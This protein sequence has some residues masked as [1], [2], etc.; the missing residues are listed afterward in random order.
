MFASDLLARKG[1]IHS[2]KGNIRTPSFVPVVHPEPSKNLVTVADFQQEFNIDFIITSSY[3]LRKRFNKTI[4]DLHELTS[5][6]GPIMTDSGA[7]QSLLYGEIELLPEEVIKFQEEIGSDFAVPLDIPISLTDSFE[8]AHEKVKITI[9]RAKEA[10]EISSKASTCWVAPIQGGKF[11]SLVERSAKELT[12]I[13]FYSMFAIGSVVELMNNYRYDTLLQIILTAKKF[14]APE[15]PLHLFGAGHP[16]MFPFIVAAGIDTFDSAAY[17]LYAQDGRYLTNTQTFLLKD[18][19]EFPCNCPICSKTTPNELLNQPKLQQIQALAKHNLYICQAEIKTIREAISS[20]TLWNLL[21]SRSRAHPALRK[22]FDVLLK[23]SSI[24]LEN[25]PSTKKKGCFYV[26]ESDSQRPEVLLHQ[27]RLK[28]IDLT[29]RKKLIIFSLLA[30][31]DIN[32]LYSVFTRV[33]EF[34]KVN[35]SLIEEFD[36][37]IINDYYGIIPLEL[38]EVYPL[39]QSVFMEKITNI[40]RKFI[41]EDIFRRIKKWSYQE[42]ILAGN[43]NS[44]YDYFIEENYY[45]ESR[46]KIKS[47]NFIISNEHFQDL[48]FFL[49]SLIK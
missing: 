34:F 32:E 9:Q 14:L 6:A 18:L 49:N 47:Y 36:F 5:F 48:E 3:I 35:K 1:I 30:N 2:P 19:D 26:S 22:G 41:I 17:S 38:I 20:G 21:E 27:Q 16:A 31:R 12:Q 11:L 45:L 8:T 40:N 28:N 23:H 39:A 4:K 13:N 43:L 25:T 44:F 29:K 15:K 37:W 7:F 33:K 24:L 42:I 10:L 46:R